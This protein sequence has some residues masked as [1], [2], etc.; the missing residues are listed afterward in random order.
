MVRG[1]PPSGSNIPRDY[2]GGT[3]GQNIFFSNNN[4]K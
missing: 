4:N 3:N 2:G 1:W